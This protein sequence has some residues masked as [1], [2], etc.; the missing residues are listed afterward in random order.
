MSNRGNISRGTD[1]SIMNPDDS[2]KVRLTF[3]DRS[4]CP[5]ETASILLV[6]LAFPF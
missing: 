5:E 3:L 6:E 4:G 1:L 2:Q